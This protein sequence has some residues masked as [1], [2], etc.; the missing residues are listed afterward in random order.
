MGEFFF[1]LKC[2]VYAAAFL[3]LL[4]VQIGGRSLDDRLM[5]FVETSPV[6]GFVGDTSAGG[7]RML[8]Q[9]FMSAKSWVQNRFSSNGERQIE[10]SRSQLR[11]EKPERQKR[12][13]DASSAEETLDY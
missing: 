2:L 5:N 1:T 3:L 9:S 13:L 12:Y 8:R 11:V 7:A 6:A 10:K 4:Q